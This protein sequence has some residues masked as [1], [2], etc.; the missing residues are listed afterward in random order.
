[1]LRGKPQAIADRN[2]RSSTHRAQQGLTMT[3]Q[4]CLRQRSAM[5]GDALKRHVL[6]RCRLFRKLP[7]IWPTQTSVLIL[8]HYTFSAW[9]LWMQT[10]VASFACRISRGQQEANLVVFLFHNLVRLNFALQLCQVKY[11]LPTVLTVALYA[12]V[13]RTS[14]VCRRL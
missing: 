11:F 14:V 10:V 3:A 12:T 4:A 13:L 6:F 7:C 1:L 9:G 8:Y 5:Q 2:E